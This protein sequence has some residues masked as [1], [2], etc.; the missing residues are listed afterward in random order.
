MGKRKVEKNDVRR[1]TPAQIEIRRRRR[2]L[3]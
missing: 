3:N 1:I 2:A